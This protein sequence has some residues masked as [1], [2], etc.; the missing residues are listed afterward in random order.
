MIPGIIGIVCCA[1][2]TEVPLHRLVPGARRLW[3]RFLLQKPQGG[4]VSRLIEE[5][6]AGHHPAASVQLE[7]RLRKPIL[8]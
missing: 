1:L 6:E 8:M 5:F 3:Q 2:K 4:A 7:D